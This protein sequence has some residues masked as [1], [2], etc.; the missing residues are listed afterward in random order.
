MSLPTP[1]D[2]HGMPSIVSRS[3]VDLVAVRGMDSGLSA[4]RHS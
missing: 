3:L 4:G 2:G 1:A